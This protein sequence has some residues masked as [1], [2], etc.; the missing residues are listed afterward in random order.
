MEAKALSLQ[1]KGQHDSQ[2]LICVADPVVRSNCPGGHGLQMFRT[3]SQ[4]WWCTVC[5]TEHSKHAVFYGC[6]TCDYDECEHCA[7]AARVANLGHAAQAP[8]SEAATL[9]AATPRGR[10]SRSPQ[11][12]NAR[13]HRAAAGSPWNGLAPAATKKGTAGANSVSPRSASPLLQTS[14]HH[15][16][17]NVIKERTKER[18]TK[19]KHVG[20][21][22]SRLT[23]GRAKLSVPIPPPPPPP[24]RRRE[25]DSSGSDDPR[26]RDEED[27]YTTDDSASSAA[28]AK[29]RRRTSARSPHVGRS[30][31]RAVGG[32]ATASAG[33]GALTAGAREPKLKRRY[34]R[35]RERRRSRAATEQVDRRGTS[36][37]RRRRLKAQSFATG[38][39]PSTPRV[40]SRRRRKGGSPSSVDD[41]DDQR[42]RDDRPSRSDNGTERRST[43]LTA[44]TVAITPRRSV[45]KDSA[46]LSGPFQQ[47][48][49]RASSR[50]GSGRSGG[51]SVRREGDND[52]LRKVLRASSAQTPSLTSATTGSPRD[53]VG[54]GSTRKAMDGALDGYA[55]NKL[56]RRRS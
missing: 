30:T 10:P 1:I 25:S 9:V 37:K 3:P 20:D 14:R 49:S 55:S 17:E 38:V 31:D 19:D 46:A 16:R 43:T 44:K 45:A 40:S 42:D 41:R 21:Q 39:D 29:G 54:R 4:G 26:R 34:A 7:L 35:S 28:A 36:K 6:R 24:P 13:G 47:Q 51:S 15:R 11:I 2:P 18:T 33:P 8:A 23:T 48:P 32:R 12:S 50:A 52:F 27:T 22:S 53:P 56:P 5:A